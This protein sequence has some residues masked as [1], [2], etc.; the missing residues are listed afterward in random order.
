MATITA[1]KVHLDLFNTKDKSIPHLFHALD[2]ARGIAALIVVL[3]H[4]PVS[5][6][7]NLFGSGDLAVD[8][9]FALSGFVLAH[10]YLGKLISGKMSFR[11]FVVARLIRLYPLYALSLM[12]TIAILIGMNF[13][14]LPLPW[15]GVAL[16]GKLPFAA[17]MLPSP[18]L[19]WHAY[20]FPFTI[21]AW[22][23][24]LELAVNIVFA[25]ICKLLCNPKTR[26][27]L[28]LISGVMLAVQLMAQNV[29]GGSSWDTLMA[30]IPRVCFSFF[31]GVHIYE[32]LAL[33]SAPKGPNNGY[34]TAAML[35]LLLVTIC[36][37]ENLLLKIA[38]IFL[39][40]PWILTV[41]ARSE[42]PKGRAGSVILKMGSL[43]YAIYIMHGPVLFAWLYLYLT[44]ET[45]AKMPAFI[46]IPILT[47]VILVSWAADRWIDTPVRQWISFHLKMLRRPSTN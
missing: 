25:L 21:A 46:V 13:L 6:R 39:L 9:F 12:L 18:S 32:T 30:G 26:L 5:F 36:A 47:S 43:S 31:L 27:T 17:L 35:S 10:A 23:I 20:L 41:L 42:I 38:A 33:R 34:I 15:T 22:S 24:F 14:G 7:G 11:N 8:F 40:F 37:P 4:L 2:A 44:P 28:I 19:D 1:Q 29:L 3:Y 45:L 16:L